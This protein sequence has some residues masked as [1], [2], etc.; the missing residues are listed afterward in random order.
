MTCVNSS[1]HFLATTALTSFW[2]T[3]LPILFLGPG[4]LRY[5][6]QHIYQHLPYTILPDPW[7]EKSIRVAAQCYIE[8]QYQAMLTH[9]TQIL[10]A[11]HEQAHS[12]RFYDILLGSWLRT[13][14][15]VLYDR[16]TALAN[17]YDGY[18][19]LTTWIPHNIASSPP[20]GNAEFVNALASDEFNLELYSHIIVYQAYPH[21]RKEIAFKKNQLS[22]KRPQRLTEQLKAQ[23]RKTL[24]AIFLTIGK[25][26]GIVIAESGISLPILLKFFSYSRGAVVPL[27]PFTDI[28]VPYDPMLRTQ[29]SA[30]PETTSKLLQLAFA[31][32]PHYLPRAYLEAYVPLKTWVEEFKMQP[33]VI[34]SAMGWH[35]SERFKFFAA[36]WSEHKTRLCGYQHGGDYGIL[37]YHHAEQHETQIT[38]QFFTWGWIG[39]SGY[40]TCTPLSG[41]KLP[42][43]IQ[44]IQKPKQPGPILYGCANNF[45]FLR[46]LN[47]SISALLNYYHWQNVFYQALTP[48]V[49][50]AFVV[51][52]YPTDWGWDRKAR[53]QAIDPNIVIQDSG[54]SFKQALRSARLYVADHISTTFAESLAAN[55]PTIL[56][57]DPEM[58]EIRPD[59]VPYFAVL[60][61]A[62]IYFEEPIAAA[63]QLNNIYDDIETWWFDTHRQTI[64]TEFRDRYCRAPA[65]MLRD[66][67]EMFAEL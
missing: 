6:E 59:A 43:L 39:T 40:A 61:A 57:G 26:N 25:K 32:L 4:C 66:W 28:V 11:V 14:L 10:N 60:K 23:L 22:T 38:D 50:R 20:L 29:L 62:G 19:R 2:D 56:F 48:A 27:P 67:Q 55:K 1:P 7:Q 46:R 13:Y 52:L 34:F 49:K 24:Q 9:L 18:P 35:Y 63:Q 53:W 51:R 65:P 58:W 36:Y 5:S 54:I 30:Q 42:K 16:M 33:Q 31:L 15:T 21:E 8:E 41:L 17:A 3:T 64:L 37:A 44:S 47:F 12:R 45:R